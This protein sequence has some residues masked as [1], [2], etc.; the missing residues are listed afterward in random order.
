MIIPLDFHVMTWSGHTLLRH[1]GPKLFC[2]EAQPNDPSPTFLAQLEVGGR[3]V[4]RAA[5]HIFTEFPDAT[6][7]HC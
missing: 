5:T 2:A 4:D 6:P 3:A 1:P 7:T